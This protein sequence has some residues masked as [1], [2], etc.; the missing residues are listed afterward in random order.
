MVGVVLNGFIRRTDTPKAIPEASSSQQ[1]MNAREWRVPHEGFA[2][3]LASLGHTPLTV[4]GYLAGVRHFGGGRAGLGS[5]SCPD[6]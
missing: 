5:L 3:Y 6:R 2:T 1:R 4:S